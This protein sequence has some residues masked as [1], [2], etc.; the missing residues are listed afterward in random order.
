M[1]VASTAN[2]PGAYIG[3][4]TTP[5]STTTM[6]RVKWKLVLRSECCRITN[7]SINEP[8]FYNL[9]M[10]LYTIIASPHTTKQCVPRIDSNLAGTTWLVLTYHKLHY[11][12]D[13]ANIR[14]RVTG[15][16]TSGY[17]GD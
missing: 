10:R 6:W 3:A 15:Y 7:F 2:K 8:P 17:Q 14:T 13:G 4:T 9:L 12:R 16:G 5:N 1:V 11:G